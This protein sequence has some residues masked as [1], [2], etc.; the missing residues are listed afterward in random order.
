MTYIVTPSQFLDVFL[1]VFLKLLEMVFFLEASRDGFLM[2]LIH[3]P[4]R[5]REG[6][7]SNTLD[8][9]FTNKEG[10]VSDIKVGTPIGKSDHGVITFKIMCDFKEPTSNNITYMYQKGNIAG[11]KQ[12]LSINWEELFQEKSVEECWKLFK[13]K[14]KST[15]ENHIPKTNT[16]TN[17]KR[18]LWMTARCLANIKKKHRAWRRYLETKE[19]RQYQEYAR[20]RNQVRRECRKAVRQYEK[21]IAEKAKANPKGFWKYVNSKLKN[22]EKISELDSTQGR[23]VTDREKAEELDKF[24][25]EVFTEEN[26]S[27]IPSFNEIRVDRPLTS[28]QITEDAVLEQLQEL[29]ISKSQ[30]PDKISPRFLSDMC[31]EV[32]KPLKIIFEKSLNEEVLPEDW[33]GANITPIYKNKGDRHQCTNYRPMSLTSIVCKILEKIIRK[34]ILNHMK[35]NSL[36][37]KEQYGFLE[38]RS[39]ITNL[40]ET[41]DEWTRITDE[42]GKLDCIYLDFMKAFDSVPHQRLLKKIFGYQIRGKVLGWL[43]SFLVGRKQ[44]VVVN[45]ECSSWESMTSGV[46]QGSVLGPILF[47]LM[48]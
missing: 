19:G 11:I 23:A 17:R 8:L 12:D 31:H 16:Y 38:G 13:A 3:E 45:G 44:R 33:K 18:P 7:R 9:I 27:A 34:E 29:N 30:G 46:P 25:K 24:Y 39:C 5:W 40:I 36:F 48:L 14:V 15:C 1:D 4:T 42:K 43:K 32:V 10:L 21:L 41:I 37:A 22:K 26:I 35:R 6:Q 47:V 2:Q 28:I 20:I